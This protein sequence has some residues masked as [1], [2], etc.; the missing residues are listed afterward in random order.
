MTVY[1][2]SNNLYFPTEIDKFVNESMVM[3]SI[4]N[5]VSSKVYLMNKRSS[6]NNSTLKVIKI[7]QTQ[8]DAL[9]PG[10]MPR[11]DWF[12]FNTCGK[13]FIETLIDNPGEAV[14]KLREFF[15]EELGNDDRTRYV[16]FITVRTL[17]AERKRLADEALHYLLNGKYD[18]FKKLLSNIIKTRFSA[19]QYYKRV[20]TKYG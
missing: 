12:F 10:L 4:T 17:F 15:G 9:L 8:L 7:I 11:I 3:P 2:V 20:S 19:R 1:R 13:S 16:L 6:Y 14:T 18:K 5:S